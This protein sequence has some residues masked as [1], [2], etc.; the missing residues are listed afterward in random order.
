MNLVLQTITCSPQHYLQLKE[1]I[2]NMEIFKFSLAGKLVG[3]VEWAEKTGKCPQC[4]A[5]PNCSACNGL[6]TVSLSVY[7]KLVK[8]FS[9]ALWQRIQKG[10]RAPCPVC[11]K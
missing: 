4:E 9:P 7:R 2:H 1:R 11:K 10:G 5:T 6:H 3:M 8:K